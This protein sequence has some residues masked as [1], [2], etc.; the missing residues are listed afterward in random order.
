MRVDTRRLYESSNGDVWHLVRD[1]GGGVFVRHA[2]NAASGGHVVDVS[3]AAFLSPDRAGPEHQELRRLI[4]T[5][6][7]Q[8]AQ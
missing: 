2:G 8:P 4:G 1:A 3:L 6:I 7:D 5:L